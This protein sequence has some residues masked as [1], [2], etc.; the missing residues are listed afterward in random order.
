MNAAIIL[1]AGEGQRFGEAIPKQYT[2]IGSKPM[3]YYTIKA[4]QSNPNIDLIVLVAR[5][6]DYTILSNIVNKYRFT[7]AK[8]LIK[9]GK[10]RKESSFNALKFL[11]NHLTDDNKVLIHDGDRPLVSQEIINSHL[12]ALN[13]YNATTTAIISDDLIAVSDDAKFIK[14]VSS[15]PKTYQVQTPQGFKFK[16]IFDA[17]RKLEDNPYRR[18]DAGLALMCD[19]KVF[20]VLGNKK[21]GKITTKEDLV[22]LKSFL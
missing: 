20:I 11:S 17:H 6:S 14:Q 12:E 15:Y 16:T 7:K 21:N 19:E 10:N 18:D 3:A 9:G 1:L 5:E 8:F 2:K 22:M 13:V 4:F